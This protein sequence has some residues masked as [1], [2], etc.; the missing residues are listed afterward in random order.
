MEVGMKPLDLVSVN[1]IPRAGN[2]YK[3]LNIE[4]L[5]AHIQTC[6]ACFDNKLYV[7]G[8]TASLQRSASQPGGMS[9]RFNRY[10]GHGIFAFFKKRIRNINRFLAFAYL[11][12]RSYCFTWSIACEACIHRSRQSHSMAFRGYSLTLVCCFER[13]QAYRSK[14]K[15]GRFFLCLGF[16][17]LDTRFDYMFSLFLLACVRGVCWKERVNL[18]AWKVV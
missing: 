10:P 5:F 14:T 12:D 18:L 17:S 16:W 4:N 3:G 15:K 7:R 1:T 11:G 13:K 6:S 2:F 8:T 9:E